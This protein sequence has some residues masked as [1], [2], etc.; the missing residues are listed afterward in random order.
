MAE[1]TCPCGEDKDHAIC[2]QRTAEGRCLRCGQYA[3]I[4]GHSLSFK[5]KMKRVSVSYGGWGMTKGTPGNH[6]R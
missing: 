5:D 2:A 3:T 1:P 4:C 6:I